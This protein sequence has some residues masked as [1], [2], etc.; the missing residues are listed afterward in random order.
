MERGILAGLAAYRWAAWGWMAAVLLLS[1]ADL[2]NASLSYALVAA[3][4]R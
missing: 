4:D 2:V 3:A 1:Q